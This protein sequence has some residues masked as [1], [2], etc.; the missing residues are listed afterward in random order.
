MFV[1]SYNPTTRAALL[2]AHDAW[3]TATPSTGYDVFLIAG[4]SNTYNGILS[5]GDSVPHTGLDDADADILQWGRW[6]A[7]NNTIISA[8]VPLDHRGYQ[9]SLPTGVVGW[10]Q[11]FAKAYKA[12][13]FLSGSRKVLLVPCGEGGTGFWSNQW[14]KGNTQY[15]DAVTRTLAA[16]ASGTGTNI[17]KGILWHQGEQ[18]SDTSAHATA[19]ASALLTMI[20]NMRTDLSNAN[21]P[22]VA[23]GMIPALISN[24]IGYYSQVQN[25]IKAIVTARKYTAYA[26]PL[27]PTELVAQGTASGS[28][29]H[30]STYS[31]RGSSNTLTDNTTLGLAGRY[32]TAYVAALSNT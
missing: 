23:G 15:T 17:L 12:Q 16:M 3:R 26:D 14:N 19:H 32:M 1:P 8:T 4:Q 10:G 7:N 13:G 28:N 20:D 27:I 22:F 18:D 6:G 9:G 31:M 25:N 2:S 29:N 24:N 5:T 11:T 21:V 30:Y